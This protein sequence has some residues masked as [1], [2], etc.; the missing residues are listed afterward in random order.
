MVLVSM[1]MRLWIASA[2]VVG[3]REVPVCTGV[4]KVGDPRVLVVLDSLAGHFEFSG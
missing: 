2:K 3:L 4:G 1:L